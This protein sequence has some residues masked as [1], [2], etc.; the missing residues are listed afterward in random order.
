MFMYVTAPEG[1]QIL[2]HLPPLRGLCCLEIK[3][4]LT[5]WARF[6][7]RFAALG[8]ALSRPELRF[9]RRFDPSP[10]LDTTREDREWTTENQRAARISSKQ[11]A[12]FRCR[13][14]SSGSS[15]RL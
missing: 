8:S 12:S 4:G 9:C 15:P 7:C 10:T 1:R 6:C 11:L 3:P 14:A 13:T 5:P 2:K